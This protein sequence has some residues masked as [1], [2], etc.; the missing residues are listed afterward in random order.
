MGKLYIKIF[1]L[2][3]TFQLV[4]IQKKKYSTTCNCKTS[5]QKKINRICIYN[6]ATPW[7]SLVA[8]DAV[9]QK[10]KLAE[11]S[12]HTH[13][14]MLATNYQIKLRLTGRDFPFED[15][16]SR[17]KPRCFVK[18][19]FNIFRIKCC[20]TQRRYSRTAKAFNM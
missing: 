9:T 8:L 10:L 17:G 3:P 5:T 12:R 11:I 20:Q 1:M 16:P 14:C 18:N 6:A 7:D 19:S 15:E 2:L 13:A 4:E